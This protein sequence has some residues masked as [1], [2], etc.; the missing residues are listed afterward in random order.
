M[1]MYRAWAPDGVDSSYTVYRW[2]YSISTT[3]DKPSS[4]IIACPNLRQ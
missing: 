4:N 2:L 1:Y 3:T